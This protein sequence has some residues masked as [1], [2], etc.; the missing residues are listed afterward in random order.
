MMLRPCRPLLL[1]RLLVCPLVCLLL[2]AA[3]AT[4][5]PAA[6]GDWPQWRGPNRDG[7]SDE[8]IRTDLKERP[9][10]L[11]GMM[12]GMGEGYASLSIVDGD[13]YT[14]GNFEDGQKVIG[15][16]LGVGG[17][18]GQIMFAT[19]ITSSAPS[20]G[21]DG[22]RSTPTND[23]DRIYV[24]GSDGQIVCLNR[25]SGKINWQR[26]F[27]DFGGQMMSG[28]GFSE[29]PLVDGDHVLCTPGGPDATIVCLNKM[30]GEEIWRS[31]P[32][33]SGDQGKD[34]AGYS[35]IVVSEAAGV[36]Q[37]VQIVG[38]GALGVRASDG[39]PL[40]TYNRVANP[41]ANI[42]T[43]VVWD[44][45]DSVFV[46]TG[47]GDGGA[48]LLKIVADESGD[49]LEVVEQYW[50]SSGELQN[51]HGGMVRVGPKLYTG[52]KHNKGFPVCVDLP[53][54]ELDWGGRIRGAGQGSA[55]VVLVGQTLI[56]RY[57]DGTVAFIEA[58]PERYNLIAKFM[59]KFQQGKSWAH[60]VVWNSTLYLREQD[61]LMA[62][63]LSP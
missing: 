61:K 43:P 63:D 11:L 41:T 34:G 10:E 50:K 12:S 18:I 54:G 2:C 21:Y 13:A 23:G 15:I 26:P 3:I 24:V 56:F 20:H 6:A 14:T 4:V 29:S 7:V 36:R 58:T 53:S 57:Q 45:E 46:S 1:V 27:S 28:W 42:P 52:N 35:S 8:P 22:S 30:T 51:H 38:R 16:E 47:Y 19:P 55:A 40:W 17:G 31:A 25:I 59:P 37:Y 32:K 44:D 5:R 33:F 48:A 9:P 60:P 62:Y 49:G 39:Q